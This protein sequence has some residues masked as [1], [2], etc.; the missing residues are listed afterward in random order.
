MF[1]IPLT[2]AYK[3]T[4]A[5]MAAYILNAESRKRPKETNFVIP[6]RVRKYVHDNLPESVIK[7]FDEINDVTKEVKLFN[8][9]VIFG[10]GGIHSVYSDN[11]VTKTDGQ[12][13]LKKIDVTSYYPNLMMLFGYMSRNTS[14]P[15]LFREI[16]ELRVRLKNEASEEVVKN[17]K[18]DKWKLL[19]AQQTALKLVLNTTYGAM[20]NKYNPLYDEF[21]A[22]S[23]C[24]LGQLLLAALANKIYKE[25]GAIIIQTNTDGIVVKILNDLEYKL[26]EIVKEWEDVTGFNME[27]DYIKLLFQRDVNNYIEVS[28]NEKKPYSLK[29]KWSNQAESQNGSIPNLNAPITHK[30]ILEFYVNDTPIENTINECSDIK[31]FCFTT[32][33]GITFTNTYHFVDDVPVETNKVNRVVATTD[34][35]YG[36]IKKYKI[37]TDEK[38]RYDKIAEIP[39]KC[40]LMNGSLEIIDDL[41]K[42][43]YIDFANNKIKE[44]R[45]I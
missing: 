7:L 4:N 41:D 14:T 9:T 11:I 5:K 18:T 10:V 35:R 20:K 31:Q 24:Y 17:G 40:K 44:L 8:N 1:K 36:T 37:G 25:T 13:K 28:Y 42:S 39:D 33:T 2:T 29:G 22:S 27:Q 30:A 38:D 15:E 34:T 3:S 21:Q 6:T 12:A 26:D 16:Y 19:N 43:W 45:W 32:K 23:L